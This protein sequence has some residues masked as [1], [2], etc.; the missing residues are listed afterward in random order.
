M[1]IR[2]LG[3]WLYSFFASLGWRIKQTAGRLGTRRTV[4]IV[5]ILLLA[6]QL[7]VF[8]VN[9]LRED[10]P[11]LGLRLE[12]RV[13]GWSN[14]DFR[15]QT[16]TIIH[17]YENKAVSVKVADISSPVSLRQLGVDV[18]EKQVYDRILARGHT[19]N[20]L[21]RLASQDAALF[22]GQNVSIGHS[23]N[24][25]IAKAYIASLDQKIDIAPANAYF[26]YQD[27]KV[28]VHPDASG[29]IIHAETA[30]AL[31]NQ[32]NPL[33]TSEVTL[34]TKQTTATVT[35]TMLESLLPEAQA[36]AQK[37]LT[38]A[39]GSSNVVLSPEQLVSLLVP[40]VTTDPKNLNEVPVNAQLSFD[41]AKLNA[42]IDEV[43][44]KAVVAPKP[45]IM[46]GSRVVRQGQ[47]GIQAADSHSLTHV[48]K[49]LIQR[50]TG[51]AAPDVAQIPLVEV[52]PPV[53]QQATG[54]GGSTARNRTGT[55]LVR[56]TFD[57]GPGGYTDQILDILKR[58]NIHGTF[59]VIGRNVPRYP[60]QM[61][62]TKNEGHKI[63]NHSH[64]HANLAR[65][66]R[67]GVV[68][69]LSDTQS[70]IQQTTGITSNCFRPPYGAHNAT[71]R[72]VAASMG[73]S[74]DMWSV[75]PRDWARPGSSAIKQRVLNGV[76]SGS[77]VLLHVLNQQ[78]V[79]ALPGIIEGIRA[80][81]YTLE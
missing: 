40:K 64:S 71:V 33:R 16:N 74:L 59:Y 23:T 45:T 47:N 62:R 43:L 57:D 79:D 32:T 68:Q 6:F 22:G 54:G 9:S 58:Y 21:T 51:V 3:D 34:P 46:N 52:S 50:Q 67:A 17:E 55:G 73:L 20:I 11:V 44:K 77:V 75:D 18:D 80:Q 66:S 36:I 38:I 39:A 25:E 72:E 7:T 1:N 31:L 81:G 37:P 65:L 60:A 76:G 13:I 61:Q 28:V 70:A 49:A 8:T 27:Q 10:D 63:C 15:K 14:G 53:V 30:L 41:E 26:A 56:L 69:E 48:F 78:T 42:Y 12:G 35:T 4:A 24:S 2:Q 19:G 29:R 5:G